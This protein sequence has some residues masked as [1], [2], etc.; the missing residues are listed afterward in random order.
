MLFSLICSCRRRRPVNGGVAG[1]S[2]GS[3]SDVRNM[4]RLRFIGPVGRPFGGYKPLTSTG[5]PLSAICLDR[6]FR[7]I[8]VSELYAA[9]GA[10]VVGRSIPVRTPRPVAQIQAAYAASAGIRLRCLQIWHIVPGLLMYLLYMAILSKL[11]CEAAY[12]LGT[13]GSWCVSSAA[14]PDCKFTFSRR[15]YQVHAA[16]RD[17]KTTCFRHGR[18]LFGILSACDRAV[19]PMLRFDLNTHII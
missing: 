3:G 19:R 15:V 8:L 17:E 11:R 12:C 5:D 1:A 9:A 13:F 16:D 4:V 14:R 10:Y 6:G 7:S 2:C 18:N